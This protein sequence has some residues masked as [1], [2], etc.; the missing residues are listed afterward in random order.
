MKQIISFADKY[1]VADEQGLDLAE[2]SNREDAVNYIVQQDDVNPEN[3]IENPF[4]EVDEH[5]QFI[6]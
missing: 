4:Y 1:I 6:G 3:I 2:F 5:G